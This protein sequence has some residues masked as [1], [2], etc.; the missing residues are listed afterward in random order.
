MPNKNCKKT[1]NTVNYLIKIRS[2]EPL[3]VF[4]L[5][6]KVKGD[7]RMVKDKFFHKVKRTAHAPRWQYRQA[8]RTK[9]GHDPGGAG[10]GSARVAGKPVMGR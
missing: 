10:R 4:D 6:V 7:F 1:E 9:A 3:P 2:I 8:T 5:L